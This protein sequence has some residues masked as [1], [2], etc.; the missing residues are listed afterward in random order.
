MLQ[1]D[2]LV[3]RAVTGDQLALATG[4]WREDLYRLSWSEARPAADSPAPAPVAVVGDGGEW[5]WAAGADTA[6]HPDWTALRAAVKAG[7]V[8][9]ETVCFTVRGEDVRGE[10]VRDEGVRGEHVRAATH[11]ALYSVQDWLDDEQFRSSRLVLVTRGAVALAAGQDAPD[12]A[13]AACAGLIRAAESEHPGRFAVIDVDGD[14]TPAAFE[15]ALSLREPTAAVR[16]SRVFVPRLSPAHVPTARTEPPLDPEGTVLI[17][18]GTGALGGLL[19]HHLVTR[20]GARHLLLL[21]RRGAQAPGAAELAG[22]LCAAGAQV[23]IVAAD[24]GERR[25][26]EQV[27]ADIPAAHPLT[28]V[29]HAAGITDDGVVSAMTVERMDTV[30]RPKADAAVLLHE[31]TEHLDLSMFVLFSSASGL[32]GNAGQANYAAANAFLD[33][34]ACHR[35]SRGLPATALAWGLWE[36]QHGM[37]A[38]LSEVNRARLAHL[39]MTALPG[40]D[41][42]ALFDAAVALGE[43]L[44]IPMRLDEQRLDEQRLATGETA[45]DSSSQQDSQT[46][47]IMCALR[48]LPPSE[49]EAAVLAF[50]RE[51]A[52]AVLAHSRPASL[53]VDAPFNSL[54]FDSLIAIQFRNRINKSSGL[55]LPATLVFEYP[56]IRAV[57]HL[58]SQKLTGP[59]QP[60]DA[61]QATPRSEV[62]TIQAMSADELIRLA[63]PDT[64]SPS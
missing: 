12:L 3:G 36:P 49:Q 4:R 23:S 25:A 60:A 30:L 24:A 39:G 21:S 26:L 34:L 47:D 43:P 32:L 16:G 33:A 38:K 44:L 31:L 59:S 2:T 48:G 50:V 45:L 15:R 42:L 17:T 56:D 52:A 57:A 27:L 37:G 19:A 7:D 54:G 61:G 18:G 28:A 10:D 22:R 41:G 5:L 11:R 8:L 29:V 14:A 62:E 63:L 1:V 64:P 20:H 9:P 13:G 58:I 35:A 51:H 53:D 40:L 46:A 55:E 6:V